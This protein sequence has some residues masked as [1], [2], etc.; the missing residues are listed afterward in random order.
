VA[1]GGVFGKR[2]STEAKEFFVRRRKIRPRSDPKKIHRS[3]TRK[4]S[5]VRRPVDVRLLVDPIGGYRIR[6]N[7]KGSLHRVTKR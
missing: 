3:T 7:L 6:G 1:R 2:A 4:S 5:Y